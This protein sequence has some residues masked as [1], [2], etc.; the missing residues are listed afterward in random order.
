MTLGEGTGAVGLQQTT[1]I[2]CLLFQRTAHIGLRDFHPMLHPFKN[3]G[4][5][6]NVMIFPNGCPLACKGLVGH[7]THKP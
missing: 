5:I 2:I 6:G 7:D 3:Q 1:Q 4:V